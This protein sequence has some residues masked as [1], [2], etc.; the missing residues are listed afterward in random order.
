ML[1]SEVSWLFSY[2]TFR[3]WGYPLL[4]RALIALN[5]FVESGATLSS[6]AFSFSIE[7]SFSICR[8]TLF[9][10]FFRSCSSFGVF[11]LSSYNPPYSRIHV[12]N[13]NHILVKGQTWWLDHVAI[14][15][16]GLTRHWLSY[17][18]IYWHSSKLVLCFLF[19]S[20]IRDLFDFNLLYHK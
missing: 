12:S 18:Y 7:I 10:S 1:R 4:L 17:V 3:F 19:I 15:Q 16:F 6:R 9:F 11:Y 8:K 5:I 13:N 2:R 14:F 20:D